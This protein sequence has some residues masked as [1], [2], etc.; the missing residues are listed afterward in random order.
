MKVGQ[1]G[2]NSGFVKNRYPYQFSRHDDGI[3]TGVS[4]FVSLP[5]QL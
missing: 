3:R 1:S 4:H 2:Y 5:E